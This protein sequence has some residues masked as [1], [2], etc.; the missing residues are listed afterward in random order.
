MDFKKGDKVK[1]LNDV[2]G[3]IVSRLLDNN[4][5]LVQIE[6]G[7]E[8]PVLV[9]ELIKTESSGE[10]SLEINMERDFNQNENSEQ[11]QSILSQ[12]EIQRDDKLRVL[13]L[14]AILPTTEKLEA[15]KAQ[16]EIYLVND[17]EY[18][19]HYIF[20]LKNSQGLNLIEKGD[21]EPEMQ[22]KITKMNYMDLLRVDS[23]CIDL[24]FYKKEFY[25]PVKPV[26]FEFS[27][28]SMNLLHS[29]LYR[30]NDYFYENALII[31]MS[32]NTQLALK[33]IQA[34][35][36]EK[37]L[38]EKPELQ[39]KKV[40]SEKDKEIEEVDLHIEQITDNFQG[41]SNGEILDIQMSRFTIALDSAIK[42][43]T[44]RI[45]FIHGVGNGKLKYELRKTLDKKYTN[46]KYHDASFAEYG[47]GAT[48]VTINH[49]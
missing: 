9:S 25:K 4:Q 24:I 28:K 45:V 27:L 17:G 40:S 35:S 3:G 5:A 42:G 48:M 22:V 41:L 38:K 33:Q 15:D 39:K 2:G 20:S 14:L 8:I 19:F 49:T 36:F 12:D 6:D 34:V 16:F 11:Q 7:F 43:K 31:E 10:I 13:P 37:A 47:F 29:S 1:F 46:I 44:K 21:L 32:D 18:F 23:F 30:Y 26:Q